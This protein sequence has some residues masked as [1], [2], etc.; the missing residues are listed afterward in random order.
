MRET[1]IFLD[2]QVR[3]RGLNVK[4]SI[5]VRSLGLSDGVESTDNFVLETSITGREAMFDF[6][7]TR[8]DY[9]LF[10]HETAGLHPLY[11][12]LINM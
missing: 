5:P 4:C 3:K 7:I 9:C 1:G 6:Q 12:T 8:W 10:H 2:S 11:R